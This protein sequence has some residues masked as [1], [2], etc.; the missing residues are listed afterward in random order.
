MKNIFMTLL[1]AAFTAL[2]AI[3]ASAHS[4]NVALIAPLS[5]QQKQQSEAIHRG[6]ML[7][8]GERD[9]HPDEV[10]DGHLGGMD[11]YVHLLD[12]NN[13]DVVGLGSVINAKNID[14][15]MPFTSMEMSVDL[16]QSIDGEARALMKSVSAPYENSQYL[17][18]ANRSEAVQKFVNSFVQKY[19]NQPGKWE[20]LGYHTARRIDAAIRPVDSVDDKDE[21]ARSLKQTE[22][23]FQW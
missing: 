10:S 21:L 11:V 19:G 15:I 5:G 22:T 14:I 12:S 3:P 23:N 4:F 2:A 20:A 8:T 6:F 18:A 1:T 13:L 17:N 9:S 7:A 16:A